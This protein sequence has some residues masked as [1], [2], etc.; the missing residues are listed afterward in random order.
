M[1]G[2]RKD[3]GEDDPAGGSYDQAEQSPGSCVRVC[4]SLAV[5]AH[6][7]DAYLNENTCAECDSVGRVNYHVVAYGIV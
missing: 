2:T 6:C 3:V 4:L 5:H 1:H 7:P